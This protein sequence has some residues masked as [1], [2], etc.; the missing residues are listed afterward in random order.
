MSFCIYQI[1]TLF[2]IEAYALSLGDTETFRIVQF[3]DI[4]M[5]N[6]AENDLKTRRIIDRILDV[7][8]PDLVIMTGDIVFGNHIKGAQTFKNLWKQVVEPIQHHGM[9]WC[10]AIGNHDIQGSLSQ[11]DVVLNDQ[12]YTNSLTQKGPYFIPLMRGLDNIANIVIF[13]LTNGPCT[14]F[15]GDPCIPSSSVNW[16]RDQFKNTQNIPIFMF[17]H[18]PLPQFV[19]VYRENSVIG[20]GLQS[21]SCPMKDTGL[22]DI[23]AKYGVKGIFVGHDHV[24]DWCGILDNVTLCYGRKTGYSSYNPKVHGA[25]V[26]EIRFDNYT[27]SINWT[28]WIR[29]ETGNLANRTIHLPTHRGQTQ[30]GSFLLRLV[31]QLHWVLPIICVC[32]FKDILICYLCSRRLHLINANVP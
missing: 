29:E 7:E 32:I 14:G 30:C 10:V 2:V 17:F 16:F 3:T 8:S 1:Y 28:T 20:D 5:N 12:N 11:E 19:D 21:V 31:N 23:A 9:P 24:N 27:D 15:V 26:I 6:H 4:H 25:R 13:D 22:F 18:I